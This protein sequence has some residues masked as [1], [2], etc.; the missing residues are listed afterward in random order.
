VPGLLIFKVY[1]IQLGI[2]SF[3]ASSGN[4]QALSGAEAMRQLLDRIAHANGVGLGEHHRRE[5]LDSA[6]AII[7][8]AAAA[9]TTRICL[10]SATTVFRA[11]ETVR[12]LQ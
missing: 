8:G 12:V 9:C 11:A 7:L 10:A 1:F 4:P 3:A 5:F 2:D 6:P